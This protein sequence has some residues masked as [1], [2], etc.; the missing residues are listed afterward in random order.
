MMKVIL[1]E[2]EFNKL[3]QLKLYAR[4]STSIGEIK[5]YRSMINCIL[6]S[7]RSK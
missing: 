2:E 7:K 1:R 5:M 6:L 3:Q 4:M